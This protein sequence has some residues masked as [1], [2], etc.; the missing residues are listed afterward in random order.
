MLGFSILAIYTYRTKTTEPTEER[1]E[2]K[3]GINGL[4]ASL[5]Q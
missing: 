2:L 5:P 1:I 3:K 4:K